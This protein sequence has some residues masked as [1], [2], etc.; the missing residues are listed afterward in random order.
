M[1][2]D[3]RRKQDRQLDCQWVLENQ[4]MEDVY[5]LIESAEE[6]GVP[7]LLEMLFRSDAGCRSEKQIHQD[8]HIL[9]EELSR[10]ILATSR[11]RNVL[12]HSLQA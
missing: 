2:N 5:L 9:G 6:C 7:L 12:P 10:K 8:K 4:Q 11:Q 1:R 3:P